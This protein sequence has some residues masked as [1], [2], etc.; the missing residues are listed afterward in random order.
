[1]AAVRSGYLLNGDN[2]LNYLEWGDA[3]SPPVLFLHGLTDCA[4]VWQPVCERLADRYHCVALSLRGHGD[5]GPSPERQYNF[6]LFASD[7][8]ALVQHL[9]WQRF[10][11]VGHSLGG[12]TSIAY[13]SNNPQQVKALVVVDVAPGLPKE[14]AWRIKSNMESMPERFESWQAAVEHLVAAGP[15]TPRRVIE[16]RAFYLLRRLPE[17]GAT[18]KLDPLV[19]QEWLGPDLPPRATADVWGALERLQCPMLVVKG[20]TSDTL[21]AELCERMV[22]FGRNSR[23]AEVP[24]ASHWVFDDNLDGFLAVLEPFLAEHAG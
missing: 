24:R 19:R 22:S 10:V 20:E 7:V 18:W 6:Q 5:S 8:A 17:G 9:G 2:P 14:A 3:D 15:G 13:A 1:M 11:L 4:Y 21:S 16:E 12:R 23:W